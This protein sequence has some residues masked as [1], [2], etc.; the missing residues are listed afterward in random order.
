MNS[1]ELNKAFAAVLLAGI[2][3][4]VTGLVSETLVHPR[5]LE[6][7][8]IKIEGAAQADAGTAAQL[9]DPPVAA[10]LVSADPA[11]GESDTKKLCVSCHTFNQGGKAGVGPNLYGVV[12]QKHGHMEGFAYST[13]LTGKSGPWTFDELYEWLK[14]PRTY[15]PGTKMSFAGLENPKSRADIIA[16]LNKNSDAPE[17]LP[18]APASSAPAA[19]APAINSDAA[20]SQPATVHGKGDQGAA[21]GD[22]KSP[23]GDGQM[24]QPSSN[25]NTPGAAAAQSQQPPGASDHITPKTDQGGQ[26]QPSPDA[27][28]P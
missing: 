26:P 4:S 9:P 20:A 10:L 19:K 24:S 7:S 27:K 17:P 21:S 25:Q 13:A 22:S 11:K 2:V 6:K 15:A 18:A 1:L 14:S 3:F 16:Y 28:S 8:A 23:A 12:G 5:K